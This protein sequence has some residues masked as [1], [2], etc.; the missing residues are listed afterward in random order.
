VCVCAAADPPYVWSL[1]LSLRVVCRVCVRVCA[2]VCVCV[3]TTS[4]RQQ[5]PS[6]I[7]LAAGGL[8]GASAQRAGSVSLLLLLLLLLLRSIWAYLPLRLPPSASAIGTAACSLEGKEEE[9]EQE[10]AEDKL[11]PN[12]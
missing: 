5:L 2:C 3:C 12:C 7:R 6:I 1:F 9:A 8:A 10:A 4:R 11:V